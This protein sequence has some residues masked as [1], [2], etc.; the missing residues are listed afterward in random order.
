[1]N[2]MGIT[3]YRMFDGKRY[4]FKSQYIKRAMWQ[5]KKSLL[6]ARGY[7]CRTHVVQMPIHKKYQIYIRKR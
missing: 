5:Q 4:K 1:M 3:T 2:T 6:Q 7:S